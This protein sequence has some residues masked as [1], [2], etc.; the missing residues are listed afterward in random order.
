MLDAAWSTLEPWCADRPCL[1]VDA[2]RY[3]RRA[4]L[5]WKVA[6]QTMARKLQMPYWW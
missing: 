5:Y 2:E 4:A 3:E 6:Q 1:H